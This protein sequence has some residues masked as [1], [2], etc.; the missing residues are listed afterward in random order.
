MDKPAEGAGALGGVRAQREYERNADRFLAMV[1]YLQAIAD[2]VRN[3]PDLPTLRAAALDA[4][5]VMMEETQDWFM[6]MK[7]H[8]FELHV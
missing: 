5:N 2:R 1:P 4:E 7:F 8:D 3:A 6:V